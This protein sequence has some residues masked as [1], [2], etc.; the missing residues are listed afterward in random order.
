MSNRQDKQD[1]RQLCPKVG[2]LVRCYFLR[3]R[4]G[5]RSFQRR[6]G[7]VVKIKDNRARVRFAPHVHLE[8]ELGAMEVLMA[9]GSLLSKFGYANKTRRQG[10]S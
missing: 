10:D 6:D 3:K 4:G 8:Y 1:M 7:V 9:S 5:K 2:D